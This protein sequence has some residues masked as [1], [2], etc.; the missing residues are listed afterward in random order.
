MLPNPGRCQILDAA[1][2]WRMPNP[3]DGH[4]LE[5]ANN[6]G[7]Q[8]LEA[9]KSRRLPHP[10]RCRIQDAATSWALSRRHILDGPQP[11]N[12][13]I[14]VAP[15]KYQVTSLS[16]YHSHTYVLHSAALGEFDAGLVRPL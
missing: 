4:I 2:S 5:I 11:G 7:C 15:R 8:I 10:G 9:D 1:T 12:R 6:G 3:G 13:Q 16:Q 14:G